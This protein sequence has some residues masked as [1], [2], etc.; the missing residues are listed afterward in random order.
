MGTKRS[1]GEVQKSAETYRNSVNSG[2]DYIQPDQVI[3]KKKSKVLINKTR[4]D[5]IESAKLITSQDSQMSMPSQ[6]ILL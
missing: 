1:S 3:E 5:S 2:P 4:N 6:D